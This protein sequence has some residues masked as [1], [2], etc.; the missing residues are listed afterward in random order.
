[1]AAL[2]LLV[3]GCGGKPA[4]LDVSSSTLDFSGEENGA[5]PAA[6]TIEIRNTGGGALEWSASADQ[7]WVKLSPENGKAPS[8]LT[9]TVDSAGLK[10]TRQAQI[11]IQPKD[12]KIASKTIAI[13]LN[14]KSSSS[15]QSGENTNTSGGSSDYTVARMDVFPPSK[16]IVAG[17]T[18]ALNVRIKNTKEQEITA[19]VSLK[20][21]GDYI[22]TPQGEALKREEKLA[23]GEAKTL[24]YEIPCCIVNGQL[25]PGPHTIEIGDQR[26]TVTALDPSKLNKDSVSADP[27]VVDEFRGLMELGQ[28]GGKVV[29]PA[30]S[31]PKTLNLALAQETSST[32]V[33]FQIHGTFLEINPLT[34]E[35]EPGLAKSWEISEDGK[36]ITFHL[37]E[38]LK[39]SDGHPITADDA[40]FTFND[41]VFNLDVPTD[42]RDPFK[43]GDSYPTVE[44]IDDLTFKMI[45]PEPYRLILRSMATY[46]APKHKLA[47]YIAKLNPGAL[48]YYQGIQDKIEGYREN[49]K[50]NQSAELAA[51]DQ[52]LGSLEAAIKEKSVEKIQTATAGTTQ[53]FG[54]LKGKLP[55]EQSDIKTDIETLSKYVGKILAEAQNGKFE[56]VSPS[57]FNRVWGTNVNPA[58]M[59]GSG[60][61]R[62]IE[63]KVDQ[64]VV[65]ERN[66][67]YWKIDKN[68]TQLPYLDEFI[69]LV[70]QNLNTSFLK[71]QAGETDTFGARP[72][73]WPLLNEGISEADCHDVER[74]KYCK[75]TAKGW[76]T[77]KG[78]PTFGT[79]FLVL[80][81]DI[82]RVDANDPKFAA[83]QAVFRNKQFRKALAY[84]MD[85][86]SMIE[87]VFHGLAV[88]QWT[89]ASVPSPF[90]DKTES[91]AKY[92]Y[93]VEKSKTMLDDLGLI[94]TDKDGTRNITDKFLKDNGLDP[95][96]VKGMPTENDREL[97]FNLTTNKGNNLRESISNLFVDDFDKIGVKVKFTPYDFNSLVTNLTGGSYEAVVIGFTGG[98]DPP[99]GKNVFR[100]DGALHFWRY[101]A[102]E[103][104]LPWEKRVDEI[105]HTGDTNFDIDVVRGAYKEFQQIVSDELPVIYT[106][107]QLFLNA[108]KMDLGNNENFN[109][110]PTEKQNGSTT[111]TYSDILWWK[112]EKKRQATQSK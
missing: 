42:D 31:G 46:I 43:I 106:A 16:V 109:P 29:A 79:E 20:M 24:Y 49:W 82:T 4:A 71:F 19:D 8:G 48:G 77:L 78:G 83:L 39:F 69:I 87:S 14:L 25:T 51:L 86:D 15:S 70:V 91:F 62:F 59:V 3:A 112:D 76:R 12:S 52:A 22:R 45:C 63:Y 35:V 95:A 111:L 108:V 74:G 26:V 9:V 56:G 28:R 61:Y 27:K 67:Y 90:F 13:T 80:N 100:S 30:L 103:S 10:G 38:G 98:T 1:M 50:K 21:N 73:D 54:A 17:G 93:D 101:T 55:E 64:Q 41:I 18:L 85:K 96:S 99:L 66:P 60:P 7:S 2:G 94:D 37:R 40:V 97:Q 110:I 102:K 33:I 68:G 11:K 53:A 36:E 5:A 32:D 107:A 23:A 92:E 89:W 47:Q 88:P 105:I 75:N 58:E 104:P 72:E 34:A 44:K 6:Q 65:L 81:Q 84:S 57:A